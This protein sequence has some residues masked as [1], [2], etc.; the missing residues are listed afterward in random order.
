M[1]GAHIKALI[2]SLPDTMFHITLLEGKI[3][4]FQ[5]S[6]SRA[7]PLNLWLVC[8]TLVADFGRNSWNEFQKKPSFAVDFDRSVSRF[9]LGSSKW[10]RAALEDGAHLELE[11][12]T[13]RRS[14]SL[15]STRI[16]SKRDLCR[17]FGYRVPPGTEHTFPGTAALLGGG[18]P[19]RQPEKGILLRRHAVLS[20]C[21]P[22]ACGESPR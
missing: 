14:R 16:E 9:A 20:E 7:A 3:E 17:T 15:R 10:R 11:N 18:E 12:R 2:V 19:G 5:G 8:S 21:R 22:S 6:R 1:I 13:A 4:S